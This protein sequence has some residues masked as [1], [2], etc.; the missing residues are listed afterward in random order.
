MQKSKN[1]KSIIKFL[2]RVLPRWA[3]CMNFVLEYEQTKP[4]LNQVTSIIITSIIMLEMETQKYSFN[5]KRLESTN[6]KSPQTIKECMWTDHS[7]DLFTSS[8]SKR[9]E[10]KRFLQL[11]RHFFPPT[12]QLHGRYAGKKIQG[13]RVLSSQVIVL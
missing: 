2:S 10:K 1:N 5:A 13:S 7:S 8:V 4:T 9:G 6:R 3:K 12:H 11:Y